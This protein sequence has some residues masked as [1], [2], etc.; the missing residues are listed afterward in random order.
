MAKLRGTWPAQIVGYPAALIL[1][2][3]GLDSAR[4]GLAYFR[5]SYTLFGTDVPDNLFWAIVNTAIGFGLI[6]LAGLALDFANGSR[7]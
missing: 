4:Y 2:L 1:F 7:R 6:A 5:L 3:L